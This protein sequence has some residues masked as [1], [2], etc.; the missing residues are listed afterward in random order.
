MLLRQ[1]ALLSKTAKVS[2]QELSKVSAALQ[3]QASRD[4]A[5]IWG[6][7]ATV[8]A[9]DSESEVPT[10]YWKMTVMD[11]IPGTGAS[12]FH[13]DAQ[14]QPYADIQYSA[15]WSLTA[16]HECLEMLV[17]PFGHHTQSGPSPKPGQGRVN[18]LVEVAD[19]CESAQCAYTINSGTQNEVWVSDFYT[20]EYFSPKRVSGVRYSFTGSLTQPR[21]VLRGGYVSWSYN[22]HIWQLFGPAQQGNFVDQGP[23]VLSREDTDRHASRTRANAHGQLASALAAGGGLKVGAFGDLFGS[24]GTQATLSLQDPTGAAM[25]VEIEYAGS[26]IGSTTQ[27]ATL[28]VQ[29]G[30]N[31]LGFVYSAPVDGDRVTLVDSVHGPLDIFF[32]DSGDPVRQYTVSAT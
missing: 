27:S 15:D 9:F 23:G 20:P 22:G 4:L 17:D 32:A 28:T 13:M 1:I 18:Y 30:N 6:I 3:K 7:S 2:S 21:Q 29:G 26:S 25:F 31:V 5:P 19:P 16:S 8:D 11:Q 24:A 10:G 14:G 12:G